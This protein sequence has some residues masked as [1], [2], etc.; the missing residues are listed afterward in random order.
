MICSTPGGQRAAEAATTA[1]TGAL[2]KPPRHLLTPRGCD[3]DWRFTSSP[4]LGNSNKQGREESPPPL[5]RDCGAD[6]DPR[7]GGDRF[8]SNSW[9]M[10]EQRLPHFAL[11]SPVQLHGDHTTAQAGTA[12]PSWRASG[13]V[14]S[15]VTSSG[16]LGHTSSQ[17]LYQDTSAKETC[18]Y[19]LLFHGNIFCWLLT[20]RY[21]MSS[22]HGG[23]QQR[24]DMHRGG[25]QSACAGRVP[26]SIISSSSPGRLFHLSHSSPVPPPNHP[27]RLA[28]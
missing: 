6:K 22:A 5:L 28:E 4:A 9:S 20:C 26:M 14:G 19:S 8:L 1:T 10:K 27:A 11:V 24:C 2:R 25:D 15:S 3:R 18:G 23:T 16:H 12:A 21:E 13:A 7:G 17:C